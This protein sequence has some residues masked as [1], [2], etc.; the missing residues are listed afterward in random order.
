[1]AVLRIVPN[2]AADRIDQA[3]AFYL[4]GLDPVMDPG[5]IAAYAA[6]CM[7]SPQFAM[8]GGSGT[9]APDVEVD[10]VDDVHGRAI[11]AGFE[12]QYGTEPRGARRFFVRDPFG[13]IVNVLSHSTA[14]ETGG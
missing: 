6:N 10:D 3:A 4:L 12:I 9:P 8:E 14:Q 5:W 1:M 11:R 2:I 13:K 7:A